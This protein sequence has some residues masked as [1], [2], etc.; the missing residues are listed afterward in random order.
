MQ[1]MNNQFCSHGSRFLT[2][3]CSY[4]LKEILLIFGKQILIHEQTLI[5]SIFQAFG[6]ILNECDVLR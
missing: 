1:N 2:C 6:A 4:C 3:M 5:E